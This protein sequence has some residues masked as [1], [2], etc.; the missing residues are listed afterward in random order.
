MMMTPWGHL[1]NMLVILESMFK[2]S[3]VIYMLNLYYLLTT[4][5]LQYSLGLNLFVF[6]LNIKAIMQIKDLQHLP[7]SLLMSV[8]CYSNNFQNCK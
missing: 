8:Q 7:S 2:N 5:H 6:R 1:T 4:V 3:A